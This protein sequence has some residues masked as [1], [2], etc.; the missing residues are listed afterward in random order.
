MVSRDLDKDLFRNGIRQ[1]HFDALLIDLVDER[2][3]LYEMTD[4]TVVTLSGEMLT[5]GM[6]NDG[7]QE[8]NKL[9]PSGSV[10][11]RAQWK[12]GISQLFSEMDE[13]GLAGRVIIN[14]VFW[15]ENLE[16]GSPL[17]TSASNGIAAANELLR[18]MYREL[19][20]YVSPERWMHFPESA[21]RINPLHRWGIAPYHYCDS[22]YRIALRKLEKI[23]AA[24]DSVEKLRLSVN[25][26]VLMISVFGTSLDTKKFLFLV[27]KGNTLVHRQPYSDHSSLQ[28]DTQSEPGLY[29]VVCTILKLNPRRPAAAAERITLTLTQEIAVQ[30]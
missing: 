23:T 14:K 29:S 7:Y 4:E 16:D 18:W 21:L 6:I 5:S 24:L 9:I 26:H 8:S 1:L 22:Y 3:N 30:V 17:P 28:F 11:H 25:N 27:F 10:R 19:E 2:F 20:R 15:S 13:L 12:S